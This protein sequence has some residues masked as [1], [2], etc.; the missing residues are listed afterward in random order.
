MMIAL[1]LLLAATTQPFYGTPW[2]LSTGNLSVSY[3]QA[4]PIGSHPRPNYLEPPPSIDSLRKLKEQG[5]VAYEDYIAWGAVEREPGK[6][7]WTRHDA[8]EKAVHAAGLK[9][10]AYCWVHFPPV[11]L[12][13]QQKDQ[14]TLMR[15][16]EHDQ[17]T[18]Y[19]SIFDPK[20][21]EH[22]DHFYRALA[23]HFGEKIDGVY[24]CILG[25]YG[26]G[27]YPLNVPDYVKI[28]H[29]HEGYWCGD[30]FARAAIGDMPQI[31]S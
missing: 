2:N 16:L 14:R 5:L 8:I 4:S 23:E 13:D 19:L 28:G 25:P 10:V 12:R 21:I 24:A 7:D 29:C 3:I 22:Y 31:K 15:C 17:E 27:N 18:N 1:M 11:W 30:S 20:T 9:Y 6:W 26:E